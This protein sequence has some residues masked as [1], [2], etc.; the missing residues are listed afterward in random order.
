MHRP[1]PPYPEN[2]G[3]DDAAPRSNPLSDSFFWRQLSA[4]GLAAVAEKVASAQELELNEALALSRASLPLLGKLVELRPTARDSGDSAARQAL[5][6]DRVASLPES[7]RPVGQALTDWHSFCRKL[8]ALRSEFSPGPAAIFWYPVVGKTL[9]RGDPGDGDFTGA[10]VL[11]AIA[12][13]RLILP[14]QVQVRAPLATLGPKLAQVALG[15]GASHLGCVAFDGQTSNDPLVADSNM[16][17]E[18]MESC[19]PTSLTCA[20]PTPS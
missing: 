12:L 1:A 3:A 20:S 16:L 13:A 15:F 7:P 19:L 10:E 6:I 11:R 8:I 4:A 14:E 17:D 2:S 18:L 5:P 9:D